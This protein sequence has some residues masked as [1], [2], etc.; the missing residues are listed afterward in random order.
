[1]I[2][3]YLNRPI[4]L[5][6]LGSNP[7]PDV[8]STARY[9]CVLEPSDTWVVWDEVIDAP[10]DSPEQL[11]GIAAPEARNACKRLNAKAEVEGWL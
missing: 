5:V 3:R 7:S 4:S 8:T 2:I 6:R 1:M 10:A 11:C 9:V